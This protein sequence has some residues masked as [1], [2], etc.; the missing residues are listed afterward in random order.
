M[1]ISICWNAC[2]M[3]FCWHSNMVHVYLHLISTFTYCFRR[4]WPNIV[5]A[6][7]LAG[8]WSPLIPLISLGSVPFIYMFGIFFRIFIC[9]SILFKLLLNLRLEISGNTFFFF[10]LSLI[11]I[12]I[13]FLK[14]F[15]WWWWYFS[16]DVLI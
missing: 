3:Y 10:F 5:I 6:A 1:I 16:S 4:T 15:L 11:Q 13:F 7:S 8:I 14:F 9:A 2:S 12:A